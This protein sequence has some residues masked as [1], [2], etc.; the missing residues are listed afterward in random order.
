MNAE[1]LASLRGIHLPPEPLWWQTTE[2]SIAAALATVALVWAAYRFV[3]RRRLRAALTEL[4]L[5]HAAFRVNGDAV[6]LARGLCGLLRSYAVARFP[7]SGV[8]GLAGS[9]WLAFLDAH[10]GNGQFMHGVGAALESLPYQAHGT[11]DAE[12]L[13]AL[14]RTW[15]QGHPQ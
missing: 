15:L 13:V 9:A 2:C 14:A 6:R 5:L 12:A 1:A 4:A 7:E 11:V 10:G 8:E 3:C